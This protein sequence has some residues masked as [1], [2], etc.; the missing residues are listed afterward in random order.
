MKR[1]LIKQARQAI[2]ITLPI[3]WIRK[4]G[5]KPGDEIDIDMHEKD[6]ILKSHKKTITGSIKLDTTEFPMRIRHLYINSAYAK[7]ID[8]IE[9]ELEKG[10]YPN[11]DQNIGFAVVSQKGNKYI[12]RDISGVSSEDLDTIFKRLFQMII[13]FYDAAIEDIFGDSKETYQNIRNRDSEINKFVL[14]LQRSIMKLSYPDPSKGKILFAYSFA[15]EKIGDEILRLWRTNIEH[16]LT[17]NEQVKEIILFSRKELSK[18]FEIYYQPNP[19]KIN[20][21]LNIRYSI[22]K[23]YIKISK[24]NS[25]TSEFLMHAIR[26]AQDSYDLAHLALMKELRPE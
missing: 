10:Q 1:N 19:E 21:S 24:L 13:S 17:K 11:V 23:K 12:I 25:A 20:D 3:E 18:A 2:T 9:M 15:L 22:V 5:L 16:R 26:I 14:F 8:E 4:N 7:G 6:L